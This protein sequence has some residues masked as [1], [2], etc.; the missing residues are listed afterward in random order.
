MPPYDA[1][2]TIHRLAL[3]QHGIFTARQARAEGVQPVAL[4]MMARRARVERLAH[5]LYRDPAAPTTRLTPYMTAVLWPLGTTGVLSHET[6]L[7]LMELS[8][9]NPAKIH[10]T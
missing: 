9:A 6:A 7:D 10:V 4:V 2:D 8:D 3:D 1:Y 5:G